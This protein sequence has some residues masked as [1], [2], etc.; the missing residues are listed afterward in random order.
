MHLKHDASELA[1][2]I[3]KDGGLTWREVLKG[4]HIYEIGDQGGLIV[5]VPYNQPTNL[6]VFSHNY[7][8]TFNFI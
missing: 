7:G 3:S 6:A 1:T 8:E 2:F 4:V 5:L